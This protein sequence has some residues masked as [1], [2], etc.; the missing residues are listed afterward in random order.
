M[1]FDGMR[2]WI[3]PREGASAPVA[4]PRQS[5]NDRLGGAVVRAGAVLVVLAGLQQL[6]RVPSGYGIEDLLGWIDEGAVRAMQR[7]WL[8][9][10][11]GGA[12]LVPGLYLT[13]DTAVFMPLY[14][15]LL[16]ALWHAARDALARHAG[17][18]ARVTPWL[19][20][21]LAPLGGSALATMLVVDLVENVAGLHRLGMTWAV[22]PGVL[23]ML[24]VI[25]W[26]ARRHDAAWLAE[27]GR[28]LR[29]RLGWHLAG[30]VLALALAWA[31]AADAECA[32]A[33]HP[34]WSAGCRAHAMKPALMLWLL[35]VPALVLLWLQITPHPDP[36]RADRIASA[37]RAVF[38][39]VWGTRYVLLALAA[40]TA[41][42]LVMN[43][44]RDVVYA[45]ASHPSD[46][47]EPV[48]AWIVT[49]VV[50]GL[51]A[52]SLLLLGYACW[53]WARL[54][55]LVA[56]PEDA[57][58][59]GPPRAEDA[60]ARQW[61]RMLG[62]APAALLL[63]LAL[64]TF[65]HAVVLQ[66][67][68]PIVILG[69]F[70]ALVLAMSVVVIFLRD[71]RPNRPRRYYR[72]EPLEAVLGLVDR[73]EYR[74]LFGIGPR[75]L[76]AVAL[77]MA[78]ACRAVAVLAP[79][80]W[81]I[82]TLTLPIV[83]CL[84]AF[85]LGVAGWISL[86][87]QGE[88]IPWFLFFVLWVGVLGLLGWAENHRVPVFDNGVLHAPGL[89]V[90]LSIAL[91]LFL[92]GVLAFALREATGGRRRG[93]LWT[94]IAVAFVGTAAFLKAGDAWLAP[95]PAPEVAAAPPAQ[96]TFSCGDDVE[97]APA[98]A[99]AAPRNVLPCAPQGLAAWLKALCRAEG[100]G[101]GC[102]GPGPLPVYVVA[103]E[104]GGIR[105]AYWTALA[106]EQ[107]RRRVPHFER[108][109]FAMTGVSGG[110]L[111]LAV[112]RACRLG[113][114][115]EQLAACIERFGRQDLLAALV[116]SWFFEDAI[117]RLVPVR[118]CDHPG[119]GFLSR[120]L[121]FEHAMVSAVD[122]PAR[123]TPAHAAA[124]AP[125]RPWRP[126]ALGMIESRRRLQAAS[127]AHVPYLFLNSTWVETGE[128]S[129]ASELVIDWRHFPG[130]R[131]QVAQL[132]LLD[133]PLVTAAH[134]SARFP[135]TNALGAV[136]TDAAGC[137]PDAFTRR[138]AGSAAEAERCGH[139]ADGGYFD[140]SG[141]Q[142]ASDLLR[143]LR[144]CL[145]APA[146]ET[147]AAACPGVHPAMRQGLAARL[148]PQLVM[149]RNG[150][151]QKAPDGADCTPPRRPRAQDVD[152]APDALP[153]SAAWL[154]RPLCAGNAALFVDTLGPVITAFA[155]IG[156]GSNGRLAAARAARLAGGGDRPS[157]HGVALFDLKED[158]ALYPLG[159]HLS[160]AAQGL[161]RRQAEARAGALFPSA[162]P[163]P[164]APGAAPAALLN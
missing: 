70:A 18:G 139:L 52:A 53:L 142:T 3:L 86:Y 66:K 38:G 61:A 9:H 43:Q 32:P 99:P 148:H 123:D 23:G 11:D 82:P 112:F 60:I 162:S 10:L 109:T 54:G 27:L 4:S 31:A 8:R 89:A 78:L 118:L 71:R 126:L 146:A 102:A 131:D 56:A 55:L 104:G 119:C 138:R 95:L 69:A 57:P 94:L 19:V 92:L 65:A 113:T 37:R 30:A 133:V 77:V 40:C 45:M 64:A 93:A 34:F 137:A 136:Q 13:L 98:G 72:S 101:A 143:L 110:S 73:P 24:P 84:V 128:R 48:R 125:D 127:G 124:G 85:W 163:Q 129:I 158:G 96:G 134:N 108:R 164:D 36:A 103:T 17:A 83:L 29:G 90:G 67:T 161:M 51:T 135:F 26:V 42:M 63:A 120:G 116:G 122:A 28:G 7:L 74:T 97:P 145:A 117:A 130:A 111:G 150:V 147:D 149:V 41:L 5:G 16:A 25:A 105:S 144:D 155:T 21:R 46:G 39:I 76:P 6:L 50:L 157:G 87:E 114:T 80:T 159:W 2:R 14:A 1:A 47:A 81:G 106:L 151:A 91:G 15:L 107:L 75:T 154:A 88:A 141:G 68:S 35:A 12:A 156:T 100:A 33:D 140:N 44:G 160:R 22:G 121:W 152:V 153:A 59:D 58:S 49:L 20:E 79:E 62:V 132:G 115:D